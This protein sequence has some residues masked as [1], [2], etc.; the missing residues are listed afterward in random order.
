MKSEDDR[1]RLGI[2]CNVEATRSFR[3]V[4]TVPMEAVQ[5]DGDRTYVLVQR[6]ENTIEQDVVL[7]LDNGT[8]VV[9]L[10]GLKNGDVVEYHST[11]V[12][13]AD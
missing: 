9:V 10:S 7:G 4:L 5:R 2:A 3:N 13:Q 1:L 8:D 12:R 6:G 11:L